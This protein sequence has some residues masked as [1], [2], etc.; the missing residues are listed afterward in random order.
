MQI[1]LNGVPQYQVISYDAKEGELTKYK[2]QD[3][4]FVLDSNG[5]IETE[6]LRGKIEVRSNG[7]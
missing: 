1:L 7:K 2:M 4:Q 3:G 6:T 5:L